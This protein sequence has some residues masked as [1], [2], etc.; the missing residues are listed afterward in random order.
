[1]EVL[2]YHNILTQGWKDSLYKGEFPKHHGTTP[3]VL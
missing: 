3:N 2:V 1:M